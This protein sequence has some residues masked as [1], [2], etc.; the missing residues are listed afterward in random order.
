VPLPFV[1]HEAP[2]YKRGRA[3]PGPTFY[4]AVLMHAVARL[5]LHP[6]FSHIQTSWVKMGHNGMR[7]ALLAGADDLGGTLMNESITRAA[8]ATHGQEMTVSEMRSLADS[9]GRTLVRRTTLYVEIA[10]T[11]PDSS[12]IARRPTQLRNPVAG[13]A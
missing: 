6:Y 1:A 3:R 12:P 11:Q 9:V 8:G 4:E 13:S 10:G 7:A 2:L 5:V